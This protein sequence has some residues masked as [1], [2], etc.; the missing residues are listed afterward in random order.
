MLLNMVRMMQIWKSLARKL[1]KR[2]WFYHSPT[3]VSLFSGGTTELLYF[4]L[5][6]GKGVAGEGISDPYVHFASKGVRYFQKL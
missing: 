6:T 5:I 2:N 4:F 1:S 3:I